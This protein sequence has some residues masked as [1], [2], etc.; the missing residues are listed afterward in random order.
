MELPREVPTEADAQREVARYW[1]RFVGGHPERA[2]LARWRAVRTP[3][4]ES[5]RRSNAAKV[6]P[7]LDAAPVV[8]DDDGVRMA[9][10][11]TDWLDAVA[12]LMGS[13]W[14]SLAGAGH[15]VSLFDAEGRMLAWDG[16]RR[17]QEGLAAINFRPGG[18]WAES[19]VGTNGPGTALETERPTHIVGAEHFCEQWH[20]WHCAAVP[21]R[22]AAAS[23]VMGAIDVSGFRE[24]AHPHALMLAAALGVAVERTLAAKEEHRRFQ[25]M[26]AYAGL[27]VRYPGDPIIAVDRA[28]R[29][30]AASCAL[31]SVILET[32]VGFMRESSHHQ[33]EETGAPILVGDRRAA[34]WFPVLEGDKLIGGCFAL[35]GAALRKGS[36][37]IPLRPGDVP[38][39][40]RRFFEA[41]ARDLG[42]LGVDVEPAVYEAMKAYPWPGGVQ[43]MKHVVRRVLVTAQG[44]IRVRHLP[45]VVREAW[46]GACDAATSPIDAEDATLMEAIHASRTMAEAAAKLGVSRSTLYRRMERFG[47][48]PRRIVARGHR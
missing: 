34:L 6:R 22:D 37:D 3:V 26:E 38:V 41:G 27:L 44:R 19:A 24:H 12:T 33:A 35:A 40:A 43:E 32:L 20:G 16:D 28:G 36:E 47:L 30:L 15:V 7:D 25:T 1:D 46:A 42:L 17:A 9:L 29:V 31:T 21:I 18:L 45:H 11:R 13:G 48:S 4:R 2:P 5:W 39:Y 23:R 14:G 10:E 8:L